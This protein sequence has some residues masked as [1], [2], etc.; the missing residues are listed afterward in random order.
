[1]CTNLYDG[2]EV[3]ISA[4]SINKTDSLEDLWSKRPIF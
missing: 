4:F 1:V 3:P 2:T